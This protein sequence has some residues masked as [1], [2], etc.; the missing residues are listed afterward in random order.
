MLYVIELSEAA[1][2][3]QR[4]WRGHWCRMNLPK[5]PVPRKRIPK[6]YVPKQRY[7]AEILRRVWARTAFEPQGDGKGGPGGRTGYL[8]NTDFGYLEY[9]IFEHIDHPPRGRETVGLVTRKLRLPIKNGRDEFIAMHDRHAWVGLPVGYEDRAERSEREAAIVS[10]QR[11]NLYAISPYNV[12]LMS[13]EARESLKKKKKQRETPKV[14][15][16][17]QGQIIESSL[18]DVLQDFGYDDR[19]EQIYRL[20][21]MP[22]I[23][24]RV[25]DEQTGHL[26]EYKGHSRWIR[27][28][29]GLDVHIPDKLAAE[30]LSLHSLGAPSLLGESD[31]GSLFVRPTI[32]EMKS[33]AI[34]VHNPNMERDSAFMQ[35][36]QKNFDKSF[37]SSDLLGQSVV[38]EDDQTNR[39]S[40]GESDDDEEGFRA[41][42]RAVSNYLCVD[43]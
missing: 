6:K 42:R 5:K 13:D 26:L 14:R 3:V 41:L 28:S 22:R 16:D 33:G 35:K 19:I 29:D 40:L 38:E 1:L 25:Y 27:V 17:A 32:T 23:G 8:H 39:D 31:D 24:T 21:G 2:S 9:D 34:A 4:T 30:R 11:K 37:G 18:V 43:M 12:P 36:H 20:P 10:Q 15:Y 7:S